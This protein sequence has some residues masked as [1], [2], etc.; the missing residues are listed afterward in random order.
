[1]QFIILTLFYFYEFLKL[2]DQP[3]MLLF[4]SFYRSLPMKFPEKGICSFPT[5][6]LNRINF[7]VEHFCAANTASITLNFP[8]NL[9]MIRVFCRKMFR[10]NTCDFLYGSYI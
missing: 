2:I 4:N 6:L 9:H 7:P 10:M 8:A 1:M 3:H 5:I